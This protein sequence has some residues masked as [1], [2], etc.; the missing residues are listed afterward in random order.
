MNASS[1]MP[2]WRGLLYVG[3]AAASWGTSGVAAAILFRDSGLGPF[4]VSFWRFVFGAGLLAAGGLALRRRRSGHTGSG[5]VRLLMIAAGMATYHAAYFAA[6]DLAGV[7]VATVVTLGSGP[8]LVAIGSRLTSGDR[9]GRSGGVTVGLALAGLL[10]LTFGDSGGAGLDR[11]SVLGIGLALLSGLGYAVV[12]VG[13]G[14]GGGDPYRTALTGFAVGAVFLLP[15]ALLEGAWPQ[16]EHLGG[17]VLI[18]AYL[19][20]VPT[21]AAYALFFAGLA[22]VRANTVAI[23]TLVEPV[24]A[25]AIA[26]WLLGEHLTGVEL[27]G[28]LLLLLAVAARAASERRPVPA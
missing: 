28:T 25:A 5:R 9:L 21:A 2:A 8:V 18:L 4:A 10:L 3:L 19:G 14:T 13:S 6:V 17:T 24:V 16:A 22:V 20:A 27:A 11:S 12:T 7:A 15:L 26:V 1:V 23:V